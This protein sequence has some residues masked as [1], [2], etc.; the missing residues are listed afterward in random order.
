M[1]EIRIIDVDDSSLDQHGLFCVKNKRH[2][3]YRAKA[4]WLSD[5]FD[6]GLRIK[7]VKVEGKT[8]GF[9]E[10]APFEASFRVITA[11]YRLVIH[12]L[13]V[14]SGE[15]GIT[16]LASCLLQEVV[17]EA[18]RQ[19]LSGVAAV[20]R[21]G[22][23]M[24]GDRVFLKNGFGE[25][26]RTDP[27]YQLLDRVMKPGPK[28]RFPVDWD[29]RRVRYPEFHLL[30]TN[31]CPYIGKIVGDLAAVAKDHGIQ[32]HLHEMND[33]AEARSKM[34]SPY[35]MFNLIHEGR[36]LA[37]HAISLTRFKNILTREMGLRSSG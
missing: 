35:G 7:L 14:N 30:Y 15:S 6:Q 19:G 16:G 12:C 22:P 18:D 20:A 21:E 28:A 9:V 32:L 24:A 2:P 4:A 34:V 5:R 25:V 10:F 29:Q 1:G 17:A 26:D 8:L 36:L 33:A 13:W 31:Q 37:D 11:P 23:W 27:D 3:G